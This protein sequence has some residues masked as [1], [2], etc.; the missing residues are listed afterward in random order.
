MVGRSVEMRKVVVPSDERRISD[1]KVRRT[2]SSDTP[3]SRPDCGGVSPEAEKE[4]LPVCQ[5]QTRIV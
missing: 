4:G 5:G 3:H 2:V 1:K